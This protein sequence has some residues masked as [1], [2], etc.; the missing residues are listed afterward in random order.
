MPS[1]EEPIQGIFARTWAL[2]TAL[3][4][5]FLTFIRSS[6]WLTRENSVSSDS[7]RDASAPTS[8]PVLKQEAIVLS[9]VKRLGDL[10]QKVDLLQT[11]PF[12]MPCEK[13]ELLNAAVCRV[14]ALEAELITTKKV[15]SVLLFTFHCFMLSMWCEITGFCR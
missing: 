2:F 14:D 15:T 3:F 13:E 4:V 7:A 5:A 10:E 6:V 8:T 12:Q 1:V 11:K 9:V